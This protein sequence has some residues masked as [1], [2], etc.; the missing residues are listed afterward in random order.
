VGAGSKA[1]AGAG[2]AVVRRGGGGVLRYFA[3]F[4]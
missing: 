3:E 1:K 4:L 2:R